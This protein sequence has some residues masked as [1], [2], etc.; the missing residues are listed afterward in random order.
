M[1]EKKTCSMGKV[2][3]QKEKYARFW[4]K[5]IHL[6]ICQKREVLSSN[7]NYGRFTLSEHKEYSAPEFITLRHH[8]L[9]YMNYMSFFPWKAYDI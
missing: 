2:K 6:P 5:G 8:R 3:V 4:V 9:I 1:T 7:I